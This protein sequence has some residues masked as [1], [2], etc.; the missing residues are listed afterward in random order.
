VLVDGVLDRLSLAGERNAVGLARADGQRCNDRGVRRGRKGHDRQR[1]KRGGAVL[2][3]AH[4][5]W[6]T[7]GHI[8]VEDFR[9]PSLNKR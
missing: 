9:A 4:L 5:G 8:F 1:Y 2:Q 7:A 3:S 6:L